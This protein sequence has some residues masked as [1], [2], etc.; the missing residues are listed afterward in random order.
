MT[1]HLTPGQIRALFG[2]RLAHG[3]GEQLLQHWD[4]C[5]FCRFGNRLRAFGLLA[6]ETACPSIADSDSDYEAAI[7]RVLSGFLGKKPK[8]PSRGD[9]LKGHEPQLQGSAE[10]GWV[11]LL[12]ERSRSFRHS[13]PRRMVEIAELAADAVEKIDPEILGSTLLADLTAR[14]LA[15]LANAYRVSDHLSLAEDTMAR[16]LRWLKRGTGD[17]LARAR[18]LDL[19]ASL[20]ADQRRPTLAIRIVEHLH[21]L[22]EELGDSHLAGRA[23]ISKGVFLGFESRP[24]EGVACVI[25]GMRRIDRQREPVLFSS[26]VET[27]INLLSEAGFY[28]QARRLE[29]LN[30]KAQG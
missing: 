25:E 11:E 14:T 9:G 1:K 3:E 16:A 29:R 30:A 10:D 26:A 5:P 17:L 12:L 6:E 24:Q 19:L 23:L 20:F 4:S 13:N 21:D 22:Y 15:E 8:R 18:V 28:S 7:E 2:G 27:S